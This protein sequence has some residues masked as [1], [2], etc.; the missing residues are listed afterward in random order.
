MVSCQGAVKDWIDEKAEDQDMRSTD[1]DNIFRISGM[2]TSRNDGYFYNSVEDF[3]NGDQTMPGVYQQCD[4][5]GDC[6]WL[7]VYATMLQK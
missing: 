4:S 3:I 7:I 2:L 6:T 5:T 1:F